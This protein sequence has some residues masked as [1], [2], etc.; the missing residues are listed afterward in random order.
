MQLRAPFSISIHVEQ[1]SVQCFLKDSQVTLHGN[2][3]LNNIA[4]ALQQYVPL[5]SLLVFACL[6]AL[7]LLIPL[8]FLISYLTTFK[9]IF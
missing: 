5:F 3:K 7:F 9:K 2:N 8:F 6:L 1:Y 4:T